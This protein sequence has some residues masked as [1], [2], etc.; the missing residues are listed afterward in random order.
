MDSKFH[1]KLQENA[2]KAIPL[3]ILYE[4]ENPL[5]HY[6]HTKRRETI[7][8]NVTKDQNMVLDVGCGDGFFLEKL[9]NAT[10]IELSKT[11]AKR[12]KTRSQKQ[13]VICSA[14]ILP[15]KNETFSNI[16]NL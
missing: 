15:F 2:A 7:I 5:K 14:E 6:I 1:R 4:S 12:A 3:T 9:K 16:I 8:K 13:V 10:G 11:R